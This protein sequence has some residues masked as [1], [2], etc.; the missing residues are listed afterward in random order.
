MVLKLLPTKLYTP[1]FRTD[2]VPRKRLIE[3]LDSGLQGK[4]TLVS[5][6]AGFGKTT[7]LSEWIHHLGYPVAWLS[8]DKNDNDLTRF[9]TYSIAALQQIVA[10][11]GIDIQAV[12]GE[13]Q[14]PNY[15]VIL[16]NIVNQLDEF[17]DSFIFVLDDF[18]LIESQSVHNALNF[19]IEYQP[20][21]MHL[22][23]SSRS[24]PLLPISRLRVR[25]DLSEIRAS[26]LRFTKEDTTVF[27]NDLMGFDLSPKNIAALEGRTE[28][29]VASLQLAALSMRERDDWPEFISAFSGSHRYVIDYLADEIM[30]R[31]PEEVQV[32]LRRTS[33]LERFCAPLCDAV[34]QVEI[35]DDSRII[36]YLE[37]FNL[38]LVPLDDHRKWY[39]FHHLFADFLQLH[40]HKDEPEQIP[41]LHQRASQWFENEGLLD[42][43]IRHALA[44]RDLERAARLV[45]SFAGSLVVRRSSKDLFHWVNQLPA[46]ICRKF[47]MLCIWHAWALFF[48]GQPDSVEPLLAI[49]EANREKVPGVPIAGYISTVRAYLANLMGDF[50]KAVALSKQAIEQMPE[51]S[52]ETDT[53]IFR[54]A[55]IIWLG[56]NNRILGNLDK[57][58]EL[59]IKAAKINEQAGSI[60]AAVSAKAQ[61][62]YLS[63]LVGQL[64]EAKEIYQQGFQV[65]ERWADEQGEGERTLVAGSELHLGLG[66]LMYEWNNLEAAATHVK[67]AVELLKL[68]GE[69]EILDAYRLLAYLC[70]AEGDYEAAVDLLRNISSLKDNFTLR[71]IN[72]L[73][74][75]RL[76]KLYIL[77]SRARPEMA[78][79][80]TEIGRRVDQMGLRPDDEIDFSGTG[81]V[82]EHEYFDLAR[83]LIALDRAAEALPLLKRLQEGARSM[84]RRGNEVRYLILNGLAH[85]A[86]GDSPAAMIFLG[87]SLTLA[88]PQG[89][90]RLFVDE[91]VPMAELLQ[92][93]ISQH[94]EPDYAEK[95]LAA[96]PD[97]I[98]AAMGVGRIGAVSDMLV[99]QLS[100]RELEVL[101]LMAE[102]YKY[103]EIGEQLVISVN[104]VRHHTRNI[105]SKLNVNN[106]AQAIARANELNL[107]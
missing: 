55:A 103:Q 74:E 89:Y 92:M 49:A 51:A 95:L 61:S 15:E 100:E 44:G 101:Q 70:Q 26:D 20:P 88:K 107:L 65:I 5:A 18:H 56:V 39:R 47:P 96:F 6:P 38:F 8:L 72:S 58:N 79:L 45:E 22:V 23:I 71:R 10:D 64:H 46:E 29:W 54:G 37:R 67:R 41:V 19:L 53:L 90:V 99:E 73:L 11:M 9:L 86:L 1:Q 27:L 105:Y 25:G 33:I 68:S 66:T 4:L 50:H 24:D 28:G 80:L 14:S 75:P 12:L 57:A 32:F 3:H 77:L 48:L 30:S 85:H 98:R 102:G 42:E 97:D 35:N 83:A 76:E 21:S 106:R 13:S 2:L 43:A 17:P 52:L 63:M 31:Q 91:G 62:A 40:L 7:L 93:A 104:T 81:Y 78:D 82:H 36:E 59:F 84:G 87:K 34:V 60:Y 69:Q 94:I 16:T